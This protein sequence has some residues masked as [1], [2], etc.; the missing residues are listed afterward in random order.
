VLLNPSLKTGVDLDSAE[1]TTSISASPDYVIS[2]ITVT[3][4]VSPA[5]ARSSPIAALDGTTRPETSGT[6]TVAMDSTASQALERLASLIRVMDGGLFGGRQTHW[7]VSWIL[8]KDRPWLAFDDLS[9]RWLRPLVGYGPDLFRYTYLLKSPPE[10]VGLSPLEP[11]HAHNCFIHQMVEQGILGAL[12]ALGLFAAVLPDGT[13]QLLLSSREMGPLH[14]LLLIA[15]LSVLAGRA[16]E[17]MAGVA[18]ISDLIVLWVL[19]G[20]F[21]ALPVAMQSSELKPQP[22]PLPKPSEA[23]CKPPCICSVD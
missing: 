3:D 22:V 9:F 17:M 11:D 7:D 12:N 1:R 2:T 23:A 14:K 20:M 13:Y 6:I 19:Q 5:M 10:S 4:S 8:I 15:I 18:R 21:A 16:V